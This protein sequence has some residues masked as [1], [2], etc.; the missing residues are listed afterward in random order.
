MSAREREY[1]YLRAELAEL[2]KLL[3]MT[4]ESAVIDRMSLEYRRSQVEAELE[5][6]PPLSRWPAS[7]HLTF[8]GKPVVDRQG[9]YA[10]FGAHTVDAFSEIVVSL[11]ASQQAA[12]GERGVIPNREDYRLLIT[13]T[14]HGSFGFEIEEVLGQAM[15]LPGESP[16]ELAIGQARNILESLTSDEETL[17]EAIAYTDERALQNVRKFLKMMADNQAVCSLSFKD[18]VFRFTDVGQVQKGLSNLGED[19]IREEDVE[20]VGH[21]QGYLPKVRRAELVDRA[22]AEVIS[23]RVD[24]K[25]ES[26]EAINGILGQTVKVSAR[27][28]QVGN[29]RRRYTILGY[30]TDPA[31]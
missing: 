11:A 19:N 1:Y 24:H 20:I 22:T 13:G 31:S 18:K 27:F 5:A 7:A 23:G 26:A 29:S 9:I 25:M 21:F 16:V 2:D 30:D 6:N 15:L 12:L 14:S 28:R 17:A 10:D 4:P 8:N 3:S